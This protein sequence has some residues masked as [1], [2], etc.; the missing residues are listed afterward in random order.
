MSC[1][2][3][4][5][6]A[7]GQGV[8]VAFAPLITRL[9]SPEAFGL[10]GLFL[11]LISLLSPAIALRYPMAIVIA[12]G[13]AEARHLA[14][15]AVGI[16]L[17][18]ACA[19]TLTIW[20]AQ[21]PILT[22]LGAQALGPLIWFL[23]LAV[24][25]VALQNVAEFQTARQG[26]FHRMGAAS[27]GQSVLANLARVL[28][29]LFA[30]VAG[31]L[32]AITALA[33]LVHAALL[34]RR[35]TQARAPVNWRESRALLYRYRDFPIYRVP[36]DMLNSAAQSVPVILLAMLH[37][38]AAAG[39]FVLARS[40]VNL[41]SN[42]IG[43]AVGNVLYARFAE[44]ARL[45]RPL[46]P[47]FRRAT[48]ALLALAPIIIALAWQ[49]P[50]AFATLFGEPWR[51]AGNY[52]RWIAVWVAMMIV[53]VP[54]TRIVPVIGVQNLQ[55]GYNVA[56]LGLGIAAVTIASHLS[57]E[58]ETAVI[59]FT[60]CCTA[61]IVLGVSVIA[62]CTR[63]FDRAQAAPKPKAN[64]ALPWPMGTGRGA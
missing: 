29:G 9:F 30:P 20:A 27:V 64:P 25:C 46:W 35:P 43:A 5:G 3:G 11:S 32:V 28:G 15:L 60:A 63:R 36:T 48:L 1:S 33:P 50:D 62:L 7:L 45:K 53:N 21:A 14:L 42:I 22:A 31:T 26:R 2:Q 13:D 55:L 18:M 44:L 54:T 23:P 51:E 38:P 61:M 34:S 24:F 8:A 58:P 52:A 10:Q 16:A 4:G 59:A 40:V 47:T 12:P 6:A 39:F 41:P 57:P 56:L 19:L 37:S 49:A 17:S